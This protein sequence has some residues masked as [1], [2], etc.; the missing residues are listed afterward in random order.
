M[1]E[2]IEFAEVPRYCIYIAGQPPIFT[3][4]PPINSSIDKSGSD[5]ANPEATPPS[6]LNRSLRWLAENLPNRRVVDHGEIDRGVLAG[7]RGVI[8]ANFGL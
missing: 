8:G 2:F 1:P 5:Q 3:D 4:T 7:A 6:T